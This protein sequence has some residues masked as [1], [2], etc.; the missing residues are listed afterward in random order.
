MDIIRAKKT[1]ELNYQIFTAE[2][3]GNMTEEEKEQYIETY[4]FKDYT[5]VD[6]TGINY[7]GERVEVF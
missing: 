1:G 6:N 4:Y 3:W 7:I 5:P 2:E